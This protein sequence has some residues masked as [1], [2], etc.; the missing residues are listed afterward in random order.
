VGGRGSVKVSGKKF[1]ADTRRAPAFTAQ[2]AEATFTKPK[3]KIVFCPM[4]SR[5]F[6]ELS[7]WRAGH[8]GY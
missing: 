8:K 5:L 1:L 3:I 6:R 7:F 4:I 2:R